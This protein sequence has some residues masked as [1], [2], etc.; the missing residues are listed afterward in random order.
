MSTY[1]LRRTMQAIPLFFILSILLF[2]LVRMVPGGP[3]AQAA[4]NPNVIQGSRLAAR[5][6]PNI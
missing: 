6:L 2:G 5:P 1:L 3:L 4:R